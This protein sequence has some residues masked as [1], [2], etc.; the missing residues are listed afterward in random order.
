MAAQIVQ[1]S[2]VLTQLDTMSFDFGLA[3]RCC[4]RG[5]TEAHDAPKQMGR[6]SIGI[7]ADD[8]AME[9]LRHAR[10]AELG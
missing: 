4:A 6:I 8:G 7:S 2:V 5:V 1:I 3:P 9:V 10:K